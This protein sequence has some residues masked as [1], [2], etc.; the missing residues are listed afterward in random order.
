MHNNSYL[1]K[2]NKNQIYVITNYNANLKNKKKN[3]A[4]ITSIQKDNNNKFKLTTQQ[5]KLSKG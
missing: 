3:R 1:T 2:K 5:W 4:C